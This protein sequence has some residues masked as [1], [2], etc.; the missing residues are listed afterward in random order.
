M[1]TTIDEANKLT[2][3]EAIEIIS[4]PGLE[5]EHKFTPSFRNA[6]KLLIEAGKFRLRWEQLLGEDALPLLPGETKE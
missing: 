1:T 4:Q 2:L 5:L 3:A 6:L